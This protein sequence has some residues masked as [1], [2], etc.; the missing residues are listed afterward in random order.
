MPT[1]FKQID[2]LQEDR[3]TSQPAN[4][5]YKVVAS[6]GAEAT[7]VEDEDI[8]L[9]NVTLG[10][11]YIVVRIMQT[12]AIKNLNLDSIRSVNYDGNRYAISGSR[13]GVTNGTRNYLT[14]ALT[15]EKQ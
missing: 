5:Q 4:R 13:R 1:L 9:Q 11:E 10:S 14:L 8:I 2:F 3:R 7:E 15:R 12:T 6:A